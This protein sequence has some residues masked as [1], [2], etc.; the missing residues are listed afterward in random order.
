MVTV[1]LAVALTLAGLAVTVQ[2]IGFVNDAL[3]GMGIDL[4]REQGWW[5]LLLSPVLLIAG[6]FLP[7][8]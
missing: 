7:N 4:T 3:S 6:S 1:I 8:L 5:A 2:P